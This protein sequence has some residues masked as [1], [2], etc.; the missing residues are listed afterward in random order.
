MLLRSLLVA[1]F[2]S[3]SAYGAT[4]PTFRAKTDDLTVDN[5]CETYKPDFFVQ[6]PITYFTI[7]IK[8]T[9]RVGLSEEVDITRSQA[10][11]LWQALYPKS[12]TSKVQKAMSKI[13]RNPMLREYFD[14]L[15][16]GK[17]ERG[18]TYNSEG[19]ILEILSYSF[20]PDSDSFLEIVSNYFQGTDFSEK[21]FFI[22]GGVTYHDKRNGRVVGELDVIVG[23]VKTCTVFGIGEAKLGGKK[24]KARRQLERIRNFIRKL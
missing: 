22:T 8:G 23:D 19:E 3:T 4:R 13:N 14:L 11:L 9:K 20:L 6:E 5:E 7:G 1:L 12:S 2:F 18:A 15:E 17:T 24:S 21:D 10:K 16:L